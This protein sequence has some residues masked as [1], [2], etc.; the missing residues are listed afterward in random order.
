MSKL[1]EQRA[2]DAFKSGITTLHF[3]RVENQVVSGM[4]DVNGINLSGREF[5]LELKA[6]DDWPARASTLPLKGAFEKGQIPFLKEKASW[7][8]I[9]YVLL[10]VKTQFY[11]LDPKPR[12]GL[13]ELVDATKYDI[14]KNAVCEGKQQ[15]INHLERL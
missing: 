15:I 2:W 4:A 3:W 8:G 6:L 13:P 9:G 12:A 5:W 7:R 1:K 10:R 14:I 11:L